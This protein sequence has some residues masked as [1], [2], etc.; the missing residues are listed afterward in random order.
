MAS[1]CTSCQVYAA[2]GVD[3][4]SVRVKPISAEEQNKID[5]LSKL[6]IA[7]VASPVLIRNIVRVV[8]KAAKKVDFSPIELLHVALQSPDVQDHIRGIPAEYISSI[9]AP[10]CVTHLLLHREHRIK[11]ISSNT[12]L[13]VILLVHGIYIPTLLV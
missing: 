8:T 7:H 1:K 3:K 4:C 5:K 11:F 6:R 9:L 12:L 13:E 2:N 10:C